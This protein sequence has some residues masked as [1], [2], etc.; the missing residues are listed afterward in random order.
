MDRH[1]HSGSAFCYRVLGPGECVFLNLGALKVS[2]QQGT[3]GEVGCL[4]L[5]VIKTGSISMSIGDEL[6][7][8]KWPIGSFSMDSLAALV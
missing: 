3:S 4:L 6:H 8:C 2:D 7:K 1:A 5:K